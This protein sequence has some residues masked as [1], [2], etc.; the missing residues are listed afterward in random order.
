MLVT[1]TSPTA[2]PSLPINFY[3]DIDGVL[4]IPRRTYRGQ[5]LSKTVF[6]KLPTFG[7]F[8]TKVPL[9]INWQEEV[10]SSL[11]SLPV[12]FVWLTAWNNQATKIWEPLTG[13]VSR[14]VLHYNFTL[15]EYR[16]HKSKYELLKN[17][18]ISNPSPFIWVDDIATKK[19]DPTHWETHADHL[20]IT[21]D[22]KYGLT[23][24]HMLNIQAFISKVTFR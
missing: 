2:I 19:Y 23:T 18:Q 12:H 11:A 4:N 17:H 21:P 9:R 10:T 20:V 1:H 16:N 5:S 24:D 14:E 15:K 3:C 13:I 22:P 7:R 8:L 6:M